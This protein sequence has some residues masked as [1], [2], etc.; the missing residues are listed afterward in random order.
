MRFLLVAL[1]VVLGFSCS[2][3]NY[4]MTVEE[5]VKELKSAHY[6]EVTLINPWNFPETYTANDIE[7]IHCSDKKGESYE[8]DN[9]PAIEMRITDSNGKRVVLYFDTV[10]L[11]DDTIYGW[12]SRILR[13]RNRGIPVGAITKI[14][15]QNGHKRYRYAD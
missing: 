2:A 9:S 11:K 10:E 6:G 15:V 12:T 1:F 4:Y 8:L 14:E 5:L 3:K 13:I 7:V